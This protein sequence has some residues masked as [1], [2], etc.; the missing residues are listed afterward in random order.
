MN[1]IGHFDNRIAD[2]DSLET[3][4][5]DKIDAQAA[6][7][8]E[9]EQAVEFWQAECTSNWK[10][11]AE[12]EAE[13]EKWAAASM[14]WCVKVEDL[15]T[16]L[17]KCMTRIKELEK[18]VADLCPIGGFDALTTWQAEKQMYMENIAELEATLKPLVAHAIIVATYM[19]DSSE[20][21]ETLL[22]LAT[23]ARHVLEGVV[24]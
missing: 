8:A 18:Q 1:E 20:A 12:L 10:R 23:D 17:A 16:K 13:K 7:I 11:I 6:R 15:E 24:K 19:P 2:K 4:L 3:E 22:K 9:L 14:D 5:R 21:Y